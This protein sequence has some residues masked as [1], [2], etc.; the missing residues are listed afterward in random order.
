VGVDLGGTWV[1][2]I[3]LR[4]GRPVARLHMRAPAV[5][6]LG[7]SLLSL[8]RRRGWARRDVA[9]LVVAARGVWTPRERL[10][11]ARR[12]RPLAQRVLVLSDAQAAHVGAL[13]GE[14]G[15]LVLSGTGSIVVGRDGA[16]RWE[17]AGGL[18]P[19]LGDDGSGFW[20]G[21]EW[22]RETT[23]GEDFAPVRR[24]VTSPDPV[25][26]VAALAPL[27]LRRARRG[28]PRARAI[29]REAQRRLGMLVVDVARRLGLAR[30]I[31]ISWAGRV[32]D[33]AWFRTGLRRAVARQGLRARWLPPAAEPVEAAARLA[34][35]LRRPRPRR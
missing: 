25:A 32:L 35:R 9:A 21:R 26:R 31:T 3:A 20:L 16:D 22:L 14:S 24:L 29:V 15:V 30:P 7:K 12:L 8:W 17:R 13:G 18:G 19:L 2:I 1:R 11:H 5:R 28:D 6:E 34:S 10:E 33:D 4:G 23:R 27:V